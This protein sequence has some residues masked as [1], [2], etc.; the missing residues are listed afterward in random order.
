MQETKKLLRRVK[1][2]KE[3]WL[4][5]FSEWRNAPTV[6]GPSPAQLFYSRQVRSCVLPELFQEP[7]IEE[8]MVERRQQ[9]REKRAERMTRQPSKGFARDE[10]VWMQSRDSLKWD[11][12]GWIR[13][14][15][16][17]GRSF[18]VETDSGGL[19]LRNRRFIKSR[20]E[21]EEAE[22]EGGKI[23]NEGDTGGLSQEKREVTA[24]KEGGKQPAGRQTYAAVTRAASRPTVPTVTQGVT[25]RS[26]ARRNGGLGGSEV[27]G[28]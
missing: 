6:E 24:G 10:K 19:Y 20:V 28:L 17:H 2:N 21:R 13:G 9:E 11:I 26:R 27:V 5:A 4:L 12:P 7:N 25:T 16:P 3:D 8:M 23:L 22:G 14:A 18:I 1:D 15:R